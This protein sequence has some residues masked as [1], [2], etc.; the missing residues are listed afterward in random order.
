MVTKNMREYFVDFITSDGIN[1]QHKKM[2]IVLKE[3]EILSNKLLIKKF[4]S[5]INADVNANL[6][7]FNIEVESKLIIL[8]DNIVRI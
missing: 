7:K 2:V 8:V 1:S 6:E 3:E 5:I 4:Q